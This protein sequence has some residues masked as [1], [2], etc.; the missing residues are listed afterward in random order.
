MFIYLLV[1][2]FS[3]IIIIFESDKLNIV[4]LAVII[5]TTDNRP[6]TINGSKKYLMDAVKVA[7]FIKTKW[8]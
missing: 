6:Q 2:K 5:L 1:Y 3:I 8:K 4:D 7:K